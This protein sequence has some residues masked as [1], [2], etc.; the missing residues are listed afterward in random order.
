MF[1]TAD[2][3]LLMPLDVDDEFITAEEVFT[4]PPGKT[5]LVAGFNALT[6][7]NNCVI[8]I[9]KDPALP[10]L[11]CDDTRATPR[12]HLGTC[13]CGR[14]IQ[15][16]SLPTLIQARLRKTRNVVDGLPIELGP[17]SSPSNPLSD[18]TSDS[19]LFAQYESMK[20]NIHVT[21]LWVQSLLLERLIASSNGEGRPGS[22]DYPDKERIWEMREDICQQ[23]LHLLNN[24]SQANLEP[25]GYFLV[26]CCVA[27]ET[28]LNI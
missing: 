6:M 24:I 27:N 7:I 13:E 20:A 25:N 22:G 19:V 8:S 18:G 14:H 10:L 3:E 9:I 17:W 28:P 16:A 21:H 5:P 1:E 23:L 12:T 26:C 15:A 11:T 4:Q 2:A